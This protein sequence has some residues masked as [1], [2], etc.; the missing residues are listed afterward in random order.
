VTLADAQLQLDT[1]LAASLA[2]AQGRSYTIGDVSLTRENSAEIRKNIDYWQ[3]KVN[4][5]SGAGSIVLRGIS[6]AR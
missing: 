1:W 4:Q 6:P 2:V 5:I 3:G